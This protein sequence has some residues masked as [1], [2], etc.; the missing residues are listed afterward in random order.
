LT[1]NKAQTKNINKKMLFEQSIT[2][3]PFKQWLWANKENRRLFWFSLIIMALS[4]TW[5][6]IVYPFPNFMPPDS[7]FYIESANNN[8]FINIWPI[9]YSIFLRMISVISKSDLLLVILQYVLLQTTI[10]Y[11]LFS[12]RYLFNPSK[13][14]FRILLCITVTNPLLLHI[15]NFVSSDSLFIVLS[16]LWFTQLLWLLYRPS[17][18]LIMTHAIILLFSFM[19]RYNALYYPFVSFVLIGFCDI[20]RRLKI[21]GIGFSIGLLLIFIG[22]TQNEYYQKTGA[23]QFSAFGGWQLAANSLYGYAI[24][25]RYPSS[26]VPRAFAPLHEVVNQ[27]MAVLEK[28]EV[29][30]DR[31]IGIYY[32]WD[33]NTPLW[34]FFLTTHK[35]DSGSIFLKWA[36][37]A[38]LYKKYGYYLITQNPWAYIK[39]F[40]LPNVSKYYVPPASFMESYNL[41]MD[42]VNYKAANWFQWKN[43]KVYT[44]SKT[45]VIS[46]VTLSTIPIA[47]INWLFLMNLCGF[48][49]AGGFKRCGIYAKRAT[50]CMLMVWLI[51]FLFSICAAPIEL[52]YQLFPLLI[53]SVFMFLYMAWLINLAF[54][55]HKVSNSNQNPESLSK[56]LIH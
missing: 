33:Q 55:Q 26:K 34:T 51:N 16:I 19:V 1:Q 21:L 48:I 9:G 12:V 24:S 4:F 46:I 45:P 27:H 8:D 40:V 14:M 31:D 6:K 41:G 30:P 50:I 56:A 22:R 3:T 25:E 28:L 37:M 23:S 35:N 47:M 52:R 43:N 38:P 13:W 17:M 42:T 49:I 32:L 39:H 18:S 44:R 5:L 7:I 53:T 11:L 20:S 54:L 10:L 36:K 29:R 15:A 2:T